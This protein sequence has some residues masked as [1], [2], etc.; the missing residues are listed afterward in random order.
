MP[1]GRPKGIW[2]P[3]IVKQRIRATK[4]MQ[5]LQNHA[6]GTL[7]N[8]V[9]GEEVPAEMTDSQIKAAVFLL[10]RLVPRAEAKKEVGLSGSLTTV[11]QWPLQKTALDQ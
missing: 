11:V 4:L 6:F 10:E 5:R 7:K 8:S 1:G 9:N 3:E 2:T